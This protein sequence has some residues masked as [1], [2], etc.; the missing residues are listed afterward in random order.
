MP[1]LIDD[2]LRRLVDVQ[3]KDRPLRAEH[4]PDVEFLLPEFLV[5]LVDGD[6]TSL[7]EPTAT[8]SARSMPLRLLSAICPPW[9]SWK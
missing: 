4:L 7:G 8:R 3:P 6:V 1:A 5:V 9:F 2:D